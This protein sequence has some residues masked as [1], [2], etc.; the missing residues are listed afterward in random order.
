M[1]AAAELRWLGPESA[2]DCVALPP[3]SVEGSAMMLNGFRGA[4]SLLQQQKCAES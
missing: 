3:A 4:L 1:S 2:Y